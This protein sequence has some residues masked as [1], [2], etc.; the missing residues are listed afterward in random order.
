MQGTTRRDNRRGVDSRHPNADFVLLEEIGD[1]FVEV[2]IRLGIVVVCQLVVITTIVSQE[3]IGRIVRLTPDTPHQ[4]SPW[5]AYGPRPSE[6]R[7]A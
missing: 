7:D 2:D 1:Q 3:S 5:A 4:G 6:P